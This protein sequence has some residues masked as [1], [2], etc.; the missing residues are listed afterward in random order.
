MAGQAQGGAGQ[1]EAQPGDVWLGRRAGGGAQ[2]WCGV[3]QGG[4]EEWGGLR[5]GEAQPVG[6][7][8]QGAQGGPPPEVGMEGDGQVVVVP[9]HGAGRIQ[10]ATVGGQDVSEAPG[11]GGHCRGRCVARGARATADEARKGTAQDAIDGRTVGRHIR[12]PGPGEDGQLAAR[13]DGLEQAQ[14]RR[15][16]EHAPEMVGLDGQDA[17][18][19]RQGQGAAIDTGQAPPGQPA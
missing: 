7:A 6:D 14:G 10:Q 13:Q 5:R 11:P 19:F 2:S 3:S 18:I 9:S 1:V 4:G 12:R 8:G 17:G 15:G 16:Q